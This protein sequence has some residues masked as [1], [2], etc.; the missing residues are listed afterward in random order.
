MSELFKDIPEFVEV[1]IPLARHPLTGRPTSE[2]VLQPEQKLL[3]RPA[4]S[5]HLNRCLTPS[6]GSF[7]EL[8]PPDLCHVMKVYGKPPTQREVSC[9][10]IGIS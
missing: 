8:G 1:S 2:R 10:W 6:A 9:V 3:V 5:V 7:R 4:C